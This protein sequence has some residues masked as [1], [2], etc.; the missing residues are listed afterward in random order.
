MAGKEKRTARRHGN[1]PEP[2]SRPG[3]PVVVDPNF[4]QRTHEELFED[5]RLRAR[6]TLPGIK[7]EMN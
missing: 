2:S 7:K 5:G 3:E 4:A 1:G 6:R